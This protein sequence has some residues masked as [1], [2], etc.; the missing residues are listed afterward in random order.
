MKRALRIVMSLVL[1]AAFPVLPRLSDAAAPAPA[2]ALVLPA[3]TAY[4]AVLTGLEDQE[5]LEGLRSLALSAT[6][7][8]GREAV[9]AVS[10]LVD[11]RIL[12]TSVAGLPS[13]GIT[14]AFQLDP[15]VLSTGHHLLEI[16]AHFGPARPEPETILFRRFHVRPPARS[17]AISGLQEGALLAADRTVTVLGILPE[18]RIRTLRAEIGGRQV[19]ETVLAVPAWK[20]QW[21][22]PLSVAT[23]GLAPGR[24]TLSLT[25]ETPEGRRLQLSARTFV[26]PRTEWP[27]VLEIP[28]ELA[29]SG[30]ET[31]AGVL[32][33][34]PRIAGLQLF[35]DGVSFPFTELVLTPLAEPG[36]RPEPVPGLDPAALS[37]DP[38][39]FSLV[40]DTLALAKG[41]HTVEV[42]VLPRDGGAP[43]PA[44]A[45]EIFVGRWE[46]K[47]VNVT[48]Y[49]NAR[50]APD[51]SSTLVTTVPLGTRF[52]I[53]DRVR[54]K[55]ATAGGITSDIWYK[56]RLVPSG[57]T[58]PVDCYI[59]S[60]F[61]AETSGA[62]ADI[63][64]EHL[65]L[66]PGVFS[67]ENPAMSAVVPEAV[68]RTRLLSVRYNRPG[69][70]IQ[71]FR[72]D[73]LLPAGD[74]ILLDPGTTRIGIR[75]L[76]GVTPLETGTLEIIRLSELMGTVVGVTA[77]AA[78]RSQPATTASQVGTVALSQRVLLL[79]RVV[80]E[81]VTA[82]KTDTWYRIRFTDTGG[83]IR[84]GYLLSAFLQPDQPE[85]DLDFYT[86]LAGFPTS[87]HTPLW[88]L[89][90]KYP[91]WRFEAYHTN[92]SFPAV[93]LAEDYK[94]KTTARSLVEKGM[95]LSWYSTDAI[96][97]D[98]Y[99]AGILHSYDGSSWYAASRE[100]IAY[101]LDPR[102]FLGERNVFQF[103]QLSFHPALHTAAGV[104]SLLSGTYMAGRTFPYAGT[105]DGQPATLAAS[106]TQAFMEAA[107]R[108][109]VSPFHLA[110]RVRQEVTTWADGAPSLSRSALGTLDAWYLCTKPETM[111]DLHPEPKPTLRGTVVGVQTTATVRSL[112]NTNSDQ[113]GT[114]ALN[115]Q[116]LVLDAEV[117][118]E[119]V[120]S[121]ETDIWCHIRFTDT[122]GTTREGYILSAF[123]SVKYW[124]SCLGYFNFYNIGASPNPSV[125]SGA[126]INGIRFATW[127][128]DASAET[129]TDLERTWLIPWTDPWRAILGGAEY[130]GRNYI[131]IGQDTLY[132]QKFDVVGP[133]YYNHQYMQNIQAA[134]HEG[135]RYYDAY[136]N[137]GLL[138]NTLVFKIP[139]YLDLPATP[140][141]RPQ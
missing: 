77:P 9:R 15:A 21:S 38:F 13:S 32:A 72:D 37:T 61:V 35:V 119:Y 74:P 108:S 93:V 62:L 128:S 58:V 70:S 137:N 86:S 113:V 4:A 116:V 141:P 107:V 31:L 80:G 73:V 17:I 30:Q 11:G 29:F 52:D 16:R 6:V 111:P 139:V 50:S 91:A 43:V 109:G 64:F 85:A 28:E 106:Y 36:F 83:T 76:D 10:L 100:A 63:D 19:A 94:T 3:E 45:G 46:G 33:H 114:I 78:V 110:S 121:Y 24:H 44:A 126:L 87:Y 105:V 42:R 98:D 12:A 101:C 66:Y 8:P 124:H 104:D 2:A 122:G 5:I 82:Y 97:Y 81:Y 131:R 27:G 34:G 136:K 75:V 47:L 26:V 7:P 135:V 115:Q 68:D 84:E 39:R 56:V 53:L 103:E 79:A 140:S 59:F 67:P 99:A 49:A 18:A 134:I 112:P 20:F 89:H 133:E 51:A 96:A 40:M 132:L 57:G 48:T 120:S 92:L 54:G 130:I 60:A 14:A 95:P 25:G 125:P 41:L 88:D 102:N 127:G 69:L 71:L 23:L 118:G 22:F 138:Q 90:L 129:V 55:T 117:Q 1:L 123:L 65:S